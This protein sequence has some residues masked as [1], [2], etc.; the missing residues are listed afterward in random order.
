MAERRRRPRKSTLH[1]TKVLNR[2]S[3]KQI[4]RLVNITTG[5]MMLI[6][7]GPVDKGKKECQVAIRQSRGKRKLQPGR[8]FEES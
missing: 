5:G 7:S 6:T 4:G 8:S 2:D 3:S 1:Y